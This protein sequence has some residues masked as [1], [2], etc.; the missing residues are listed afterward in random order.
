MADTDTHI[1]FR[2]PIPILLFCRWPIPVL[3]FRRWPIPILLFRRWPIPILVSV[4]WPILILGLV[5]Q[6]SKTTKAVFSLPYV[7]MLKK[8]RLTFSLRATF[9]V[10]LL[11]YTGYFISISLLNIRNKVSVDCPENFQVPIPI[12]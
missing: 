8:I 1:F 12:S 2:W 10:N 11:F 3:L 7:I 6:G 4:R 9:I 5:T